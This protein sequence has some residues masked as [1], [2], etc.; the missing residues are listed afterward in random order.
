MFALFL[1]RT[2]YPIYRNSCVPSSRYLQ[3]KIK[4]LLQ[5]YT[6]R[7][8]GQ[9]KRIIDKQKWMINMPALITVLTLVEL[10]LYEVF[11]VQP[12][13]PILGQH[14]LHDIC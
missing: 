10:V 5:E 6:L 14:P 12:E 11:R 7:T 13:P 1:K 3:P 2:D 9:V 4:L 8:G